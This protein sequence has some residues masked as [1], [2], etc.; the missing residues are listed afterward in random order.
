MTQAN[1]ITYD[2]LEHA[3]E[4]E[5]KLYRDGIDRLR[6][7]ATADIENEVYDITFLL[8]EAVELACVLR[9]LTRGRTVNELHAAFGAPGDFGYENPI[10]AA[11][12]R[13]YSGKE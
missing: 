13:A 7:I 2:K 6:E 3:I 9:R 11:L 4:D 5:V 1:P 10:G 8:K 12:Y